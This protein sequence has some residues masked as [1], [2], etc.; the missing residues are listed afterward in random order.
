MKNHSMASPV[1]LQNQFSGLCFVEDYLMCVTVLPVSMCVHHMCVT[2][3]APYVRDCLAGVYVC[4]LHAGVL[5]T[6]KS[7]RNILE[8]QA[9]VSCH[10]EAGNFQV[11]CKKKKCS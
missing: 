4:V 1:D 6:W 8:L 3:C 9:V 10:G 7:Q 11:L 5:G 2:V